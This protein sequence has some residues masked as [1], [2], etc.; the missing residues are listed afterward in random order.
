MVG[1]TESPAIGPVSRRSLKGWDA[2]IDVQAP[3]S[4]TC[5]IS[6]CILFMR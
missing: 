6:T 4:R 3:A 2:H 1:V 5:S